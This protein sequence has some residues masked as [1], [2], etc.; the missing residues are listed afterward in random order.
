MPND[1]ITYARVWVHVHTRYN[2]KSI[3]SKDDEDWLNGEEYDSSDIEAITDKHQIRETCQEFANISALTV[4][5]EW[6]YSSEGDNYGNQLCSRKLF[7]FFNP[8]RPE[9]LIKRLNQIRKEHNE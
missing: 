6:T 7:E 3:P 2:G 4:A 9:P 5:I 1:K 8:I